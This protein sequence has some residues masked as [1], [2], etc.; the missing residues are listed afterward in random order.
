MRSA[1]RRSVTSPNWK[2]ANLKNASANGALALAGKARGEDAGGWF[3]CEVAAAEHDAKS[4]SHEHTYNEDTA[5][6]RPQLES[7]L[8]RLS[9]MVGRRL[10]ES[11]FHARTVQLKPALQRLL[12]L[13]TRAHTPP[14][15]T[16]AG[17]GNLRAH[18]RL[19]S[20]RIGRRECK[21]ACFGVHASSFTTQSG[22]IDLLLKGIASSAG[23]T[24][25]LAADKLRDKSR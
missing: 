7:T 2:K 17:Y 3:D 23:K 19:V 5:L 18:P 4:I 6:I 12:R 16:A 24:L 10:R 13:F 20:A 15:P 22:Q 8:M 14:N 21:S 9:E 1:S 11:N 25:S